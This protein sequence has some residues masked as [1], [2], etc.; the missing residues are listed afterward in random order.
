MIQVSSRNRHSS[1]D[2][3]S[4]CGLSTLTI[5]HPNGSRGCPSTAGMKEKFGRS[6][7]L[8]HNHPL[9]RIAIDVKDFL[10]IPTSKR[11]R[12]GLSIECDPKALSPGHCQLSGEP[13]FRSD[14]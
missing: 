14:F 12:A 6:S 4:E 5:L 1:G 11:D 10:G 13:E 8:P 9:I 2:A 7:W 3:H